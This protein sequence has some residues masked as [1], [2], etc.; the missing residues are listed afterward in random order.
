M[1]IELSTQT[2]PHGPVNKMLRAN[3][4]DMLETVG[5]RMLSYLKEWLRE[6]DRSHA[7]RMGWPHSHFYGQFGNSLFM[8]V[9]SSEIDI[10][11]TQPGFLL[12]YYGGDVTPVHGSKYLTIPATGE[13]YNHAAREFNNLVPLIR[14]VGGIPRAVALVEEDEGSA[15]YASTGKGVRARRG[16]TENDRNRGVK[17]VRSDTDD[18]GRRIF[19]WLVAQ[20]H[21]SADKSIMPTE[22]EMKNE[23]TSAAISYLNN[24]LN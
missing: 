12:H 13:S 16:I 9:G 19:Y 14:R 6:L 2:I 23:A 15:E 4:Q 1:N 8:R 17:G 7:N 3:D 24:L 18:E 5:R 21:I 20:A 22:I 11:G 10:G